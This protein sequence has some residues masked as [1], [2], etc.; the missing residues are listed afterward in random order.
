MLL[1]LQWLLSDWQM[2]HSVSFSALTLSLGA[3][4][5]I[6]PQRFSPNKC[7]TISEANQGS[8]GK[9]PLNGGGGQLSMVTTSR[10]LSQSF[11]LT[12]QNLSNCRLDNL[13]SAPPTV[14]K[15]QYS[16]PFLKACYFLLV[17]MHY[18]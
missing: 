15:G 6:N 3:T 11:Q 12:S 4:Q 5:P 14:N 10:A 9:W 7:R 18:I 1:L 16:S 17:Y 2:F 13:P 8:P